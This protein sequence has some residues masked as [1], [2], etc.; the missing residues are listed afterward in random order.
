M[1]FFAEKVYRKAEENT[2][3]SESK[4]GVGHIVG[5]SEHGVVPMMTW[6]VLTLD[7]QKVL[8]HSQIRRYSSQDTQ[9]VLYYC[10]QIHP[11]SSQDPNLP[12]QTFK[13]YQIAL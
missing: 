13:N 12:L 10:S 5:I 1:T 9:K 7:A 6:K 11:Y 8:Y 2:F 4:A 3:P